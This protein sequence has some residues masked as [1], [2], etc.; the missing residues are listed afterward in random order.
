MLP[1]QE[2]KTTALHQKLVT[3]LKNK[4]AIRSDS[5][6]SAFRNV[7]RHLF[8]PHV[9]IEDAY[10][11]KVIPTKLNMLG[12][13][14]IS[15]SSQPTMMAVMLEQLALTKGNKVLE[16]GAGTG[17]NAALMSYIVSKEGQVISLDID[18]DIIQAA[19]ENLLKSDQNVNFIQADGAHGYAELAPY[20]RIVLT[21]A[22]NDILPSWLEQLKP[23]GRL[24]LPLALFEN[25]VSITFQKHPDYLLSLSQTGCEFMG[26]RGVYA[27]KTPNVS[28]ANLEL[29]KQLNKHVPYEI[30]VYPKEK[31]NSVKGEFILETSHNYFV[32]DFRSLN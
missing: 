21:V 30:R 14:W 7:P 4:G 10:S 25:Q 19:K 22:A 12:T 29:Q 32:F 23:E 15:S 27:F 17:Y 3:H 31:S 28:K 11:D 18:K 2:E 1:N 8:V 16:I 6:E 20:D 24:L 5:V 9:S 13:H 26:L